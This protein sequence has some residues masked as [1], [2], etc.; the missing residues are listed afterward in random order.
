MNYFSPNEFLLLGLHVVLIEEFT[1][2]S[3]KKYNEKVER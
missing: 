3:S 1:K 2:I